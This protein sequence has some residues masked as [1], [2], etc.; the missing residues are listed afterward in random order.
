MGYW[1]VGVS[2]IGVRLRVRVRDG[3]EAAFPELLSNPPGT[4][5]KG[6][7]IGRRSFIA[8]WWAGRIDLG[9]LIDWGK[10]NMQTPFSTMDPITLNADMDRAC[11]GETPL[12]GPLRLQK[13]SPSSGRN[14]KLP[15]QIFL[16]I[17]R[18]A[19]H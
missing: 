3:V 13:S 10:Q 8:P 19:F 12:S 15:L 11:H 2:V 4:A 9:G 18:E 1:G 14:V 6:L 16:N 7:K 17:L 5:Q